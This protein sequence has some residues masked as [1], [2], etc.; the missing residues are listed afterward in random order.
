MKIWYGS[1]LHCDFW[2]GKKITDFLDLRKYDNYILAGDTGEWKMGKGPCLDA[3]LNPLLRSGRASKVIEIAGN[4]T[5]YRGE[6]AYTLDNLWDFDSAEPNYSF[7]ENQFKDFPEERLRIWGSTLWTNFLNSEDCRE[8]AA[9]YMNDYRQIMKNRSYGDIYLHPED[10]E[11]MF[12]RAR[13]SLKAASDSLPADWRLI[14]VTHHA[15]TLLSVGRKFQDPRYSLLNGAYAN[16]MYDWLCENNIQPSVWIHGHIHERANYELDINGHICRVVSNTFGY[17]NEIDRSK[18]AD[19][20]IEILED[21]I[22][23]V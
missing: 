6:M 10:T 3:V 20:H 7:L 16:D 9:M 1:D 17:P 8:A 2:E 21:R 5:Y 13:T 4:H 18:F 22:I 19:R 11:A 12:Y 23:V 14:V 15:P